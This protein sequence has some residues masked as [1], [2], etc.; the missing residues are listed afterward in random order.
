MLLYFS[1]SRP[2][3]RAS[4]PISNF[5][6]VFLKH[7]VAP[8]G[9]YILIFPPSQVAKI[10]SAIPRYFVTPSPPPP[11]SNLSCLTSLLVAGLWSHEYIELNI[12]ER[13]LHRQLVGLK[14]NFTFRHACFTSRTR[15][16]YVARHSRETSSISVRVH[17]YLFYRF[18]C[19]VSI[20]NNSMVSRAIWKKNMHS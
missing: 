15:A 11:P 2:E 9:R 4:T 6:S 14:P 18:L 16:V 3:N 10:I 12:P 7:V 19:T 5:Y 1:A 20:G 8:A 17:L 13:Y